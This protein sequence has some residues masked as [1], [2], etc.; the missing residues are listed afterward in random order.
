MNHNYHR[1]RLLLAQHASEPDW[2]SDLIGSLERAIVL[3][4]GPSGN[5]VTA[6]VSAYE[7]VI[8]IPCHCLKSPRVRNV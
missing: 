7:R 6:A 5:V 4:P 2:V 3:L 8:L 1:S